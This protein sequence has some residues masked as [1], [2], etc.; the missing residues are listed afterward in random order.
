MATVQDVIA[1]ALIKNAADAG[2][3]DDLVA[4]R[5]GPLNLAK[6]CEGY[7]D[8][9]AVEKMKMIVTC[10]VVLKAWESSSNADEVSESSESSE[11]SESSES[12]ESSE[13]DPVIPDEQE[14]A[15]PEPLEKR[16]E[17]DEPEPEALA[18]R[19]RVDPREGS[20]Q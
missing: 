20:G 19:K 1:R 11:A 10:A 3:L 5:N 9:S 13:A 15:E 14:L 16:K 2:R 4:D 17:P 6:M 7:E 12:S 8:M 18:K